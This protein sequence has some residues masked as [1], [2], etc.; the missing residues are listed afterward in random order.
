[1]KNNKMLI[2][3]L[4]LSFFII[5]II[6]LLITAVCLRIKNES[7][8]I[9]KSSKD[10]IIITN[11][12]E[13]M[14]SRRYVE[15]K[16]YIDELSVV[17]VTK[18]FE[19]NNQVITVDG[20]TFQGRFFGTEIPNGYTV[21]LRIHDLKENFDI[22]KSV[23]IIL[24]KDDQVTEIS[25]IIEREIVDS[26]NKPEISNE[27]F[28]E[29]EISLDEYEV[30]PIKYSYK[31]NSYVVTTKGDDDWYNY[32]A[33]EWAKVLVFPI[34]GEDLK[35]HFI[36]SNGNINNQINYNGY[37]LDLKNYIYAWIPNFSIKDSISYFRYGNGKNII[38]QDLLYNNGEYL[39]LNTISEVIPDV[40]DE[41]NF[42]GI[43]GVWRKIDNEDDIY[44][45]NFNVTRFGPINL[46]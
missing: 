34:Y 31:T 13:N 43:S 27:Y 20:N 45:N 7:K 8:N 10:S 26:C 6:S 37:K 35:N 30:I 14:N 3:E 1:M 11:I 42:N 33:K 29:L 4:I 46:H 2:I 40:S 39:Y 5:I 23:N 32:Y 21:E 36:N 24:K 25:S 41:C 28:K 15:I 12:L 18:T 44:F 16:E 19:E 17:G 38:K 9:N 22:Q